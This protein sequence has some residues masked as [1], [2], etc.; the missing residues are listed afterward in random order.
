MSWTLSSS[1]LISSHRVDYFDSE[2]G[3]VAT[4][5]K[6]LQIE[7][8]GK[9]IETRYIPLYR[10]KIK[11]GKEFG[12]IWTLKEIKGIKK[13]DLSVWIIELQVTTALN[14]RE[15]RIYLNNYFKDKSPKPV[16]EN[17]Y[18]IV[19]SET[20]NIDHLLIYIKTNDYNFGNTG[21]NGKVCLI[22]LNQ[23]ETNNFY[24]LKPILPYKNTTR[25]QTLKNLDKLALVN[26]QLINQVQKEPTSKTEM[27]K[28]FLSEKERLPGVQPLP[29]YQNLERALKRKSEKEP[30]IQSAEKAAKK[31]SGLIQLYPKSKEELFEIF[32]SKKYENYTIQVV[33]TPK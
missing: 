28:T 10:V 22:I 15:L 2:K 33:L 17:S 13:E 21:S 7:R 5:E 8:Q 29:I 3:R 24:I 32:E 16:S 30:E 31:T 18:D 19:N 1:E 14:D 27:V 9:D 11:S 23:K 26:E 6:Q 25:D 20:P 12:L 4:T